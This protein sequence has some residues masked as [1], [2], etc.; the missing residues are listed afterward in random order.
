M[1]TKKQRRTYVIQLLEKLKENEKLQARMKVRGIRKSFLFS[2]SF[3]SPTSVKAYTAAAIKPKIV[4]LYKKRYQFMTYE[5]FQYNFE[6]TFHIKMA[7]K[8]F[9]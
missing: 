9:I 3:F 6:F 4:G 1:Q 2:T 7:S 8:H 5:I